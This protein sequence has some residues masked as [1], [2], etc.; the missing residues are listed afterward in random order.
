MSNAEQNSSA[1]PFWRFSLGF[2]R[3]A[4]V[5]EACLQLQDRCGAD[6]NIVLFMLWTATL[7]HRLRPDAVQALADK[8]RAWQTDVIAPI[9]NLRRLLKVDPLLL[10]KG[11]AEVFR[12]KIKALEL[13][14]ERLQQEAMFALSAELKSEHAP[15]AEAARANIAAYQ[16]V[17]GQPFDAAGID[18]LT[19][20][21]G[22]AAETL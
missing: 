6:V 4:G 9:R 20:A 18:T 5:A 17:I 14:A 10:D 11:N 2:Y 12:N 16:D 15:V 21:L 1:S 22:S 13:E 7:Q 8:M 3:L 19:K